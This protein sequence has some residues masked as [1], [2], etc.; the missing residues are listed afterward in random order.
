M[1]SLLP[2]RTG[3]AEAVWLNRPMPQPPTEEQRLTLPQCPIINVPFADGHGHVERHEC[4]NYAVNIWPCDKCSSHPG[5]MTDEAVSHF[6]DP[7]PTHQTD[8]FTHPR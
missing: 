7:H 5:D 8:L 3:T 4:G 2:G 6:C 1:S